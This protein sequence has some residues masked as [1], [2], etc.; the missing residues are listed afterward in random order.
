[1]LLSVSANF[2]MILKCQLSLD[3]LRS[4]L[5]RRCKTN[6]ENGNLSLK[7]KPVQNYSTDGKWKTGNAKIIT[8]VIFDTSNNYI[9]TSARQIFLCFKFF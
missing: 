9:E 4:S 5:F 2:F 7:K 3:L 6:S 8:K 1:M